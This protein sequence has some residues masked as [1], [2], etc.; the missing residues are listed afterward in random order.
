MPP[1]IEKGKII[2]HPQGMTVGNHIIEMVN[3]K[4]RMAS[5]HIKAG[6]NIDLPLMATVSV[7]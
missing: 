2:I 4:V 7:C 6:R 1:V 5:H 3:A